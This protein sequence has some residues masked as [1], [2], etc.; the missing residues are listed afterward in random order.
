VLPTDLLLAALAEE[1]G[2]TTKAVWVAR[3]KGVAAQQRRH[4]PGGTR[5]CVLLLSN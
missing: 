1:V 2:L 5:E 4:Q 3:A